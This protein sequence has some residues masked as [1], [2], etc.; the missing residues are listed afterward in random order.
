M[1]IC[2]ERLSWRYNEGRLTVESCNEMCSSVTTNHR[3]ESNKGMSV[4]RRM[5]KKHNFVEIRRLNQS[6]KKSEAEANLCSGRHLERPMT[7][8][9]KV[10]LHAANG[11]G[12][13]TVT[14]NITHQGVREDTVGRHRSGLFARKMR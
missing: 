1:E 3:S 8:V 11:L 5:D 12:W 9:I 13:R 10:A 6:P 4:P 14:N 7:V 2:G